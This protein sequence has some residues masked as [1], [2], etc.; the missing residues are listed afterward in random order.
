MA[1]DE[2]NVYWITQDYPGGPT[3]VVTAPIGGGP[4]EPVATVP[5]QGVFVDATNI[6]CSA[7]FSVTKVPLDGSPPVTLL[8]L[9][10]GTGSS[11]MDATTDSTNLY[12]LTYDCLLRKVPLDGSPPTTFATEPT[13]KGFEAGS[14]CGGWM[15]IDETT[16]YVSLNYA[17]TVTK[18]PL[19][20][21]EDP[22][23]LASDQGSP[24]EIAVDDGSVYWTNATT[25]A[26]MKLTPK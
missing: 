11:V 19:D 17:G 2:T 9:H 6:Y 4:T 14:G 26:V 18:V 22:V 5:C 16:A 3:T 20:G 8:E 15:A 25:D 1:V 23:T 24:G 13:P 10:G 21:S 12:V 7:S